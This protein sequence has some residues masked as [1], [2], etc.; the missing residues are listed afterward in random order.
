MHLSISCCRARCLQLSRAA[1]V[2]S[3]FF[4]TFQSP[5]Q[6]RENAHA[7]ALRMILAHPER[8]ESLI[9]QDAVAHNEGLGEN[10]KTRRAFWA[11]RA[12]NEKRP[13]HKSPLDG[14][15][16]L[17]SRRRRSQRRTP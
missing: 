13:A 3:M 8:V 16:A 6:A 12:A 17:A 14:H 11:D 7:K 15:H 4:S 1:L 9:V 5:A 10:W 2:V